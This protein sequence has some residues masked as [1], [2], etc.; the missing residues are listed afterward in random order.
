MG[1]RVRSILPLLCYYDVFSPIRFTNRIFS[2]FLVTLHGSSLPLPTTCYLPVVPIA[3]GQ[4]ALVV[5][6]LIGY[7]LNSTQLLPCLTWGQDVR[8]HSCQWRCTDGHLGQ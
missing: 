1:I 5:G 2:M 7:F 8:V 4:Y 6:P 3:Y